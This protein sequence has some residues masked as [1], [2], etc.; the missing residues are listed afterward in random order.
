[1]NRNIVSLMLI[2][3]LVSGCAGMT[4]QRQ[5]IFEGTAIGAASGAA[6]GAGIGQALGQSTEATLI[7]AGIGALAGG[8]AGNMYGTH[9]ADK[10]AEYASTEE[11]LN[12]CIASAKEANTQA[13]AYN[14][15]LAKNNKILEKDV[16]KLVTSY[17]QSEVDAG[18]MRTKQKEINALIAEQEVNLKAIRHQIAKQQ[19]AL[20]QG[21]DGSQASIASLDAEIKKLEKEARSLEQETMAL[22]SINQRVKI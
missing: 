19:D 16:Q 6:I 11:Y 21:Q 1:M 20:Q 10:K 7:G 17:N 9:I 22:A 5:T 3:L 12:A 18:A 4:D 15:R 14:V 8:T 13:R 2:L